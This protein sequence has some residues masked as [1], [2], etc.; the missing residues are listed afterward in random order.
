MPDSFEHLFISDRLEERNYK[1]LNAGGA[2]HR[3]YKDNRSHGQKLLNNIKRNIA[4]NIQNLPDDYCTYI[5]VNGTDEIIENLKSLENSTYN[6]KI[7]NIK[8]ISDNN[9]NITISVNK[10]Y[11]SQLFKKINDYI[12]EFNEKSGFNYGSIIGNRVCNCGKI[13]KGRLRCFYKQPP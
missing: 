11:L 5:T 1:T 2:K 7:S 6:V 8:E 13:R 3:V 4:D 12:N 10:K 9:Y